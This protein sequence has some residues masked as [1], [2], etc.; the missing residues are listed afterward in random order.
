[1]SDAARSLQ[2]VNDDDEMADC[3]VSCDGTWQR[4]CFS[5]N[6]CV[7]VMSI[8]TGK[9]L[10]TEPLSP[11]CEQCQLHSHLDKES[12]EYQTWKANHTQCSANF[13]G[14]GPCHGA[15]RCLANVQKV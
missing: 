15:R 14:S 6:G 11:T 4:S 1:M 9:V 12:V 2:K 5:L 10:D 8:D 3:A 13:K 7:T